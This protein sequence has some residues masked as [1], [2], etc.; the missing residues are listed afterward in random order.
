MIF[1]KI[2]LEMLTQKINQNFCTNRIQIKTQIRIL[3]NNLIL[4]DIVQEKT[5]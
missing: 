5:F 3:I 1:I 4:K 2:Q